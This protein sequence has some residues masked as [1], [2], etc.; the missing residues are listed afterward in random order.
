MILDGGI[1]RSLIEDAILDEPIDAVIDLG[2]QSGHLRWVLLLA[3]RHRGGDNPTLGIHPNVQFLPAFVLLLA[4]LLA[5]PFALATELQTAAVNDQGYCFLRGTSDLLSDR[6]GGV[7]TRQRRM[8]R[9]RKRQVH[10]LQEYR[11]YK[12]TFHASTA[13]GATGGSP[14][15]ASLAQSAQAAG[16][17][18][19]ALRA[20][21]G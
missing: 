12:A 4:V 18:R 5:M 16:R 14:S 3:F 15:R 19:L 6:H 8:I 7:T 2:H 20:G 10:E 1:D 21:A 13:A 11:K 9:A 17:R